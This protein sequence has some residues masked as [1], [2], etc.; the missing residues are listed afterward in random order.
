ML[1][2]RKLKASTALC[3]YQSVYDLGLSKILSNE[4]TQ[5]LEEQKHRN[6]R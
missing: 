4:Y 1:C 2:L 6:K 3:V 5:L